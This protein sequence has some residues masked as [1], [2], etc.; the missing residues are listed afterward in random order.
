MARV[1]RGTKARTRRK[2]ILDRAEGFQGRRRNCYTIA[3]VAVDH[4]LAYA[5][6]GRK[7]RKRNFRA[8]WIQRINAACR[9]LGLS[10]S[11]LVPLLKKAEIEIDRKMLAHLAVTDRKAFDQIVATAKS[12]V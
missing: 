4:A 2:K 6:V 3:K 8:L 10:Y 12:A 5:Y 7:Q 11:K 9:Q 1:K